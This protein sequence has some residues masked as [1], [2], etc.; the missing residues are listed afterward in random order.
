MQLIACQVYLG[1]A[2][3]DINGSTFK[4]FWQNY[5]FPSSDTNYTLVK[6]LQNF[7]FKVAGRKLKVINIAN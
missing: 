4:G 5:C 3:E 2:F 6:V 1:K 7:I